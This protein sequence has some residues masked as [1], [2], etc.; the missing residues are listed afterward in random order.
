VAYIIGAY[1]TAAGSP[2]LGKFVLALARDD[3]G[4]WLIVSD[5]DNGNG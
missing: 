5:I 1:A 4:R 2:D 3:A